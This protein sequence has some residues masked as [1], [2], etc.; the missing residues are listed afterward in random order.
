LRA[1]TTNRVVEP[2]RQAGNQFLKRFTNTG[3]CRYR[4]EEKSTERKTKRDIYREEEPGW[5]EKQN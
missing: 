3:S 2:L 5:V 1:G 4:S